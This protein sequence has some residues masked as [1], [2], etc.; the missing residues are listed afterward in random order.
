[1]TID[2]IVIDGI[3]IGGV[4]IVLDILQGGKGRNRCCGR[5]EQDDPA[6]AMIRRQIYTESIP[7]RCSQAKLKM[8]DGRSY[9]PGNQWTVYLDPWNRP[10]CPFRVDPY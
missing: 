7:Y 4:V 2:G 10:N 3:V 6:D 9:R 1:M 8:P 5:S